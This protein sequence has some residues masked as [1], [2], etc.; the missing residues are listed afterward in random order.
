MAA[1]SAV[2]SIKHVRKQRIFWRCLQLVPT[3][4]DH[5]G[6]YVCHNRVPRGFVQMDIADLLPKQCNGVAILNGVLPNVEWSNHHLD[7][8]V[9]IGGLE[10]LY[11]HLRRTPFSHMHADL[12]VWGNSLCL[13]EE[14]ASDSMLLW[15]SE[16]IKVGEALGLGVEGTRHLMLDTY[17]ARTDMEASLPG[18]AFDA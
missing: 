5:G 4:H 8:T 9:L 13:C 18:N 1:S 7:Y 16:Q 17:H 14:W 2:Q 11:A 15:A 6:R 12:L 10:P 3:R